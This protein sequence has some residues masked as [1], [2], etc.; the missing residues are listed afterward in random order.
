M[1]CQGSRTKI[2]SISTPL[3]LYSLQL[4]LKSASTQTQHWKP[5]L[6]HWARAKP[7][8]SAEPTTALIKIRIGRV[9]VGAGQAAVVFRSLEVT[10][11]NADSAL[12]SRLYFTR[13]ASRLLW[14]LSH[15]KQL[16]MYCRVD[17]IALYSVWTRS[18]FLARA[19]ETHIRIHKK[20]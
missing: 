13:K 20:T 2:D 8:F 17:M 11:G 19:W 14:M 5:P 1:S 3:G 9:Q 10:E 7:V 12:I 18:T 15:W 4:R 16:L 6:Q